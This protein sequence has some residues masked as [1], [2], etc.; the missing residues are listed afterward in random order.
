M[1]RRIMGEKDNHQKMVK[2]AYTKWLE[3]VMGEY[4]LKPSTMAEWMGCSNSAIS[5]MQNRLE[6]RTPS[7]EEL[8]RFSKHSGI[9][10]DDILSEIFSFE[11]VNEPEAD[12]Q[13]PGKDE[14]LI[15][16]FRRLQQK[17]Q[18]LVLDLWEVVKRRK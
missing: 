4:G 11:N 7:V 3:K 16:R 5:K 13:K 8:Y 9:S 18:E 10:V 1:I 17:D 14:E 6:S 15:K 12:T 2:S